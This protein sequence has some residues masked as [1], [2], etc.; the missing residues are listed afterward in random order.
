VQPLSKKRSSNQIP[1]DQVHHQRYRS[2]T[3]QKSA[4]EQAVSFHQLLQK[5]QG[6]ENTIQ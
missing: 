1:E 6:K 5:T 2:T 3:Q 4:R